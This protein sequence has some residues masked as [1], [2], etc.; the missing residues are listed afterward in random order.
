MKQF[1]ALIMV[2]GC[3]L[4]MSNAEAAIRYRGKVW[5]SV[6]SGTLQN[7]IVLFQSS[8]PS[9][10]TGTDR[11]RSLTPGAR[12]LAPQASVAIEFQPDG[13]FEGSLG[14][15]VCGVEGTGT[16]YSALSGAYACINGDFGT[17]YFGR[18]R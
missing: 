10:W 5:S 2:A 1:L 12:C 6:V 15:G 4:T 11:C 9:H 3:M 13:S 17:F 7:R 14:G 16:P 18:L 8:D